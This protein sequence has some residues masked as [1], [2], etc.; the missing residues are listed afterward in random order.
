MVAITLSSC[1][2]GETQEHLLERFVL[3]RKLHHA[4]ALLDE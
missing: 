1:F 3:R 2:S 4:K